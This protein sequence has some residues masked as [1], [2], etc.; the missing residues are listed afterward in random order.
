METWGIPSGVSH[1]PLLQ[2]SGQSERSSSPHEVQV[3]CEE[4]RLDGLR[5][6]DGKDLRG[7]AACLP[8]CAPVT[9]HAFV[10][11]LLTYR[12]LW[13]IARTLKPVR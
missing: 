11:N 10:I 9:Y 3:V 12:T 2:D 8:I 1:F 6:R 13:H 7:S 5:L 4:V